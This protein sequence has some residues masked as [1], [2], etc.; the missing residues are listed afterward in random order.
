MSR[1]NPLRQYVV[2][3]LQLAPTR[4]LGS[5]NV[6]K[7]V[8]QTSVMQPTTFTYVKDK[9]P[10]YVVSPLQLAPTRDLGSYNVS[11]GV[12]QTSVMQPVT[13][14]DVRDKIP[15]Y[16]VS[17]VQLPSTS[18]LSSHNVVKGVLEVPSTSSHCVIC[19]KST[20]VRQMRKVTKKT[21]EGMLK[22]AHSLG[23]KPLA[24]RCNFFDE[25]VV[26]QIYHHKCLVKLWEDAE[27]QGK[28]TVNY[29]EYERKRQHCFV[30]LRFER[31]FMKTA[32]FT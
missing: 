13:L 27:K 15:Q 6:S 3:P 17:P 4:D 12:D 18:D 24:G 16:V 2:S 32:T 8:A 7:G 10:Q 14:T 19:K 1:I 20:K 28:V 22:L 9:A 5:Y 25:G 26:D 11:K 31:H 21:N 23:T 30:L 29:L